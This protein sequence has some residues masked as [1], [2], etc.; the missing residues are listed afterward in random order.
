MCQ[1]LS[2]K[3]TEKNLKTKKTC[4]TNEMSVDNC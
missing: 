4:K 2:S 1:V 3:D